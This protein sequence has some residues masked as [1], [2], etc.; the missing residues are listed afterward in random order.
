VDV[1]GGKL[2]VMLLD[3]SPGFYNQEKAMSNIA[4]ARKLAEK[5]AKSK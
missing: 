1:A 4:E 5:T 3:G 2:N